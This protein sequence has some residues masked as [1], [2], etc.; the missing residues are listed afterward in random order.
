M[1]DPP[2]HSDPIILP[3]TLTIPDPGGPRPSGRWGRI[4]SVPP[5]ADDPDWFRRQVEADKRIRAIQA[6]AGRFPLYRPVPWPMPGA[7]APS[8]AEI[9]EEVRQARRRAGFALGEIA[10]GEYGSAAGHL[11]L[12]RPYP[13][14]VDD[15]AGA[16]VRNEAPADATPPAEPSRAPKLNEENAKAGKSMADRLAGPLDERH[17]QDAEQDRLGKPVRDKDG[18]I[19]DHESEVAEAKQGLKKISISLEL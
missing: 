2:R 4:G 11:L 18:K 8:S 10:Q 12:G 17:L 13:A 5:G 19:Y 7:D 1:D 3:I 14:E 15:P 6:N 9:M 16:I